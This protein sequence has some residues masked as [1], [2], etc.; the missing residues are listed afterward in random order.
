MQTNKPACIICNKKVSNRQR[1]ECDVCFQIS[2]AKCNFLN[3]IDAKIIENQN[4]SW[5][6]LDCSRKIFPFIELNDYKFDAAANNGHAFSVADDKLSFI[7]PRNLTSLHNH[8][9]N[10]ASDNNDNP[11]NI[12]NCKYYDVD[13][14][15]QIN[16]LINDKSLSLFHLNISSLSKHI[17]SLENLISSTKIE[18]DVIAISESRIS[19]D[20]DASNLNLVNYSLEFCPTL[21]NAGGTA[22]YIKNSLS[23]APRPDLQ[24]NKP[25]QLES[26]FI[27]IITSKKTNIIIGCIYRHPNMDLDEFNELYLNVLL[28][29]LNKEN[30]SIF[31][32]GDFNVD[33]LKYDKNSLTNE[34]L[35]SLSSH[36]FLPNIVLPTRI[37]NNSKTLIDNIF[38]NHISSDVISGNIAVS[39]SDHLPQFSIIPDVFANCSQPKSNIFERDWKNFD[40]NQFILDFSTTDWNSIIFRND[41]DVNKLFE[42]F[43]KIFN[44]LLDKHAPFKKINKR[45][46]KFKQKPWITSSIQNSIEI[47]NKFFKKYINTKDETLK[48]FFHEKYKTYRNL[49]STL[50]KR[51]KQSYYENFFNRNINDIK[52]T[53]KGIKSIISNC[54]SNSSVPNCISYNNTTITDPKLIANT[55]NRYF[56]SIAQNIQ[57]N[58]KFSF[59][60]FDYYLGDVFEKSFFISPTDCFEIADIISNL[61]S[62]KSDGPNGLPTKI[63]Q[64]LKNEISPIL[65]N[66]FNQSFSHGV[67]PSILKTAKVIPIHKKLSKL[68]CS[69]YRPISILSNIDKIIERLMHKRL[70]NF[71]EENQIVYPLQFGFRKNFSTTLA[72]LSLTE[73]IQQE[74]DKGRFGCGIFI[75][76]QKAFDTVD[77]NILVK[78]LDHYG[79]RGVSNSWFKSYLNNRKQYV[80]INGFNSELD[81]IKCGVPQGSILG[82]LLF[83]LYI[84]DL[85]ASIM[86]SKVHHFADDTNLLHFSNSVKLLNKQINC[87][88]KHLVN[89]LNANKISL[90][91]SKT[92]L[93]LF[94]PL[95][96]ELDHELK[97]KLNGKQVRHAWSQ[98]QYKIKLHKD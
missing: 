10:L 27:E 89:W 61:S 9:N 47:K 93:V 75:D 55:F 19:N 73:E 34:F 2:H 77:H 67:F 95:K 60:D 59:R 78:K 40:E 53:W 3:S 12:I 6:C 33:L 36:F 52:H 15:H 76:F 1:I 13:E 4:Q 91:I 38:S 56:C 98:V 83:L 7:P 42:E 92:E 68:S 70:Y 86:F 29:K 8:F 90:N 64:L 88:L 32:L 11:D 46:L 63:M 81:D 54:N 66:L 21:S 24:I 25:S 17:E 5:Q 16:E 51:S 26:N 57:S 44:I 14:M 84:N 69:N 71:V 97:I 62:D 72:L 20:S 28:E 82:P 80:S 23:F 37:S 31:L 39:I 58:I 96:K 65:A 45:K 30:K 79:I 43:F 35:D 74:M 87:D 85:H 48:H 22:I 50:L 49:L 18:F 94:K 41:H